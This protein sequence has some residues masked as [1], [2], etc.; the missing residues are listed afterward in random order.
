M[1]RGRLPDMT[2]IGLVGAGHMGAGLG[3][4]LR[5]G[6][7]EV[8]TTLA[9]RSARTA[10][11]AHAAGV[12]TLA[13]LDAVVAAAEVV[14][15]VTPPGA[16]PD[17]A[18]AIAAA[19]AATGA[20]PLV[21]DLN[22]VS[23]STVEGIGL[24]LGRAGLDLVDG[25][26]SGPPPTVTPGARIYLSGPRA[27]EIAELAWR[28][29]TPVVVGED[30]GRASA[31]KMCTASVY[32]GLTG[33]LA[34]AMRTAAHH[35]VLDTV[36]A[37]LD[38]LGGRTPQ[39]GVAVSATKAHRYVAEMHEIAATQAGAGLPPSLF[40]A[41]AEVYTGLSQTDLAQQE[42]E[43]VDRSMTAADVIARLAPPIRSTRA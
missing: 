4:A 19:A 38:G 40:E 15:V 28:H 30:V 23:P 37:D 32:K 13:D 7:H 36:L 25:S 21:A 17:A 1:P 9:G 14:L 29:V 18:A 2:T 16:A 11:L 26:I 3:W 39:V 22:A 6:G 12:A 33:L 5:E 31:V 20:R 24:A 27:G 41:Y 8:V 10:R 34:Q 35:G 42:P 43:S